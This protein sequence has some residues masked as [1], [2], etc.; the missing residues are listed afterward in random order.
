MISAKHLDF[1]DVNFEDFAKRIVK[2]ETEMKEF[3]TYYST[4][5][6]KIKEADDTKRKATYRYLYELALSNLQEKHAEWYDDIK[7]F[8]TDPRY[9]LEEQLDDARKLIRLFLARYGSYEEYLNLKNKIQSEG[10]ADGVKLAESQGVWDTL[11]S[12]VSSAKNKVAG[13]FGIGASQTTTA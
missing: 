1:I 5:S 2:Q 10:K 4:L 8:L 3:I 7:P 6:K 11:K 13:W 9:T 12:Y